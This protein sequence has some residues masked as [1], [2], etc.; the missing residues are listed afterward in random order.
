MSAKHVA[1]M[2]ALAGEGLYLA[3]TTGR[4]DLREQS[5]RLAIAAVSH[6]DAPAFLAGVALAL[7]EQHQ[8]EAMETLDREDNKQP[9]AGEVADP[10]QDPTDASIAPDHDVVGIVRSRTVT[11]AGRVQA[12]VSNL[13]R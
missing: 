13:A 12:A 1:E 3:K 11:G 10:E 8:P 2:L 5:E 9:V 7:A 4:S 6:P